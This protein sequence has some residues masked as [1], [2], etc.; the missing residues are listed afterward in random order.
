MYRPALHRRA[1]FR[2]LGY[3]D[4]HVFHHDVGGGLARPTCSA[5]AGSG[6]DGRVAGYVTNFRESIASFACRRVANHTLPDW[7]MPGWM[8]PWNRVAA[9]ALLF[10][11]SACFTDD[12]PG[13]WV[14]DGSGRMRAGP[15]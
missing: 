7:V 10:P 13:A 6:L 3:R 5:G 4:D 2:Y 14:I 9:F 1:G 12:A 11:A 8:Q 15:Q